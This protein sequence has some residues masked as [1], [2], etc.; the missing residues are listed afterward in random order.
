MLDSP[1][2]GHNAAKQPETGGIAADRLISI[3]QRIE[4]LEQERK[5][6]SS[7]I[8]DIYKEAHSAGFVPK[9]L[10]QVVRLRKMDVADREEQE[11]LLDLYKR[12]VGM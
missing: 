8:T 10:R 5:D 2:P 3:V 4:K 7:D 9:V 1:G 12:A 11:T 6:I